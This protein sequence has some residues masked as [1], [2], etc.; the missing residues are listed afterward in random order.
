MRIDVTTTVSLKDDDGK[1]IYRGLGKSRT[2]YFERDD[3][4]EAIARRVN[5]SLQTVKKWVHS[6][7]EAV[8]RET[9]T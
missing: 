2:A 5:A 8:L 4:Q 7:I 6:A 3:D 1:E 9:R